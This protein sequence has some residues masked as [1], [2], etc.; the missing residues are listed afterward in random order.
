MLGNHDV[1][2]ICGPW[3]EFEDHEL[4][5]IDRYVGSGGG[6]LVLGEAGPTEFVEPL[7]AKHGVLLD[8]V[9]LFSPIWGGEADFETNQLADHPALETAKYMITN[10]AG[11]LVIDDPAEALLWTDGDIWRD[12]DENG[13]QDEDDPVGPFVLAAAHDAGRVRVAVISDSPFQDHSYYGRGNEQF[14]RS[15]LRWLAGER[16][17]YG[18]EIALPAVLKE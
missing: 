15:V 2:I 9:V 14:I 16:P 10:Y 12:I 11:S 3:V 4:L 17:E 7:I 6:L 8:G 18:Y 1:A 13:Q 5:A